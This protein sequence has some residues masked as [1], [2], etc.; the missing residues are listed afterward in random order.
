M[1]V[2][3][4]VIQTIMSSEVSC[5][6]LWKR[7]RSQQKEK[8]RHM[9]HFAKYKQNLK[10]PHSWRRPRLCTSHSSCSIVFSPNGRNDI[11]SCGCVGVCLCV[12]Y[13]VFQQQSKPGKCDFNDLTACIIKR[14]KFHSD[15]GWEVMYWFS[16]TLILR[17]SMW[18]LCPQIINTLT[19]SFCVIII[20]VVICEV[21]ICSMVFC[22]GC[23]PTKA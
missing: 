4:R 16:F 20:V 13:L 23:H 15:N 11:Y 17:L 3:Q 21:L 18:Q 1:T 19:V 8:T 2:S 7:S 9:H 12:C 5:V 22:L 14:S 10:T 6:A